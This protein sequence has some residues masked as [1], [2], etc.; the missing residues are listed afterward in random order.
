MIKTKIIHLF[1]LMLTGLLISWREWTSTNTLV[2]EDLI[3]NNWHQIKEVGSTTEASTVL[4][5]FLL[6]AISIFVVNDWRQASPK[7]SSPNSV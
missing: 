3:V 6:G 7:L 1:F 5:L 4:L 2:E